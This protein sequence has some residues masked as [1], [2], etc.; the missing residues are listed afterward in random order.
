[1]FRTG[2]SNNIPNFIQTRVQ[3]GCQK[4]Q[5]H[6]WGFSLK[7]I[8]VFCWKSWWSLFYASVFV[9][10]Y[11][12]IP[13]VNHL[14]IWNLTGAIILRNPGMLTITEIFKSRNWHLNISKLIRWNKLRVTIDHVWGDCLFD[15]KKRCKAKQVS[16]KLAAYSRWLLIQGDI[17]AELTVLALCYQI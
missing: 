12:Y 6:H 8:E 2:V 3:L 1:M 4:Q 10:F 16:F 15:I 17:E 9:T 14:I 5:M 13:V 7:K 11:S